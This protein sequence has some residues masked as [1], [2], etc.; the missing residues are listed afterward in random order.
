[1]KAT[2]RVLAVLAVMV[3]A[4]SL[5][6]ANTI[7]VYS[8]SLDPMSTF[9]TPAGGG[10]TTS[11]VVVSLSSLAAYLVPGYSISFNAVGSVCFQPSVQFCN[12]SSATNEGPVSGISNPIIGGFLGA[13]GLGGGFISTPGTTH[14]N[15]GSG[16]TGDW[17]TDIANT[18]VVTSV[19]TGTIS[20]PTG[21]TS[22]VFV[23]RDA[24][25]QDNADFSQ[26]LNVDAT[27]SAPGVPEPATYGMMIVGLGA[28]LTLKRVRRS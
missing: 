12:S 18:F 13:G 27:F 3:G 4:T 1:M 17:T 24:F 26:T 5:A 16:G 10:T 22:V 7:A 14:V 6:S 9:G 11:A 25:Y 21:A 20:I 15:L 19:G 23:F 28:L 2:C 8:P